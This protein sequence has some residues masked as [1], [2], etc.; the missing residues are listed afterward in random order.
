MKCVHR[1]VTGQRRC[2]EPLHAWGSASHT[3]AKEDET[4]AGTVLLR[5]YV[6]RV[7]PSGRF[8]VSRGY[9]LKMCVRAYGVA[10]D[11]RRD[12]A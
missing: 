7:N 2:D 1:S 4:Y 3:P 9:M 5:D 12:L 11:E 10:S 8:Y 6:R